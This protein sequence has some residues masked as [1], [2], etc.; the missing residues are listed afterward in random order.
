MCSSFPFSILPLLHLIYP[1]LLLKI[2]DTNLCGTWTAYRKQLPLT[3]NSPAN[4]LLDSFFLSVISN[5]FCSLY[6]PLSLLHGYCC[7]AFICQ[8]PVGDERCDALRCHE[9]SRIESSRVKLSSVELSRLLSKRVHQQLH[10]LTHLN[11]YTF[12]HPQIPWHTDTL[13]QAQ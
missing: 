6:F 8:L 2:I 10:T 11:T 1:L 5:Y 7:C 13:I 12:T 3:H 9:L 4:V